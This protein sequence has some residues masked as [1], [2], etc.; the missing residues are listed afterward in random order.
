MFDRKKQQGLC[1]TEVTGTLQGRNNR[2]FVGHKQTTDTLNDKRSNRDSTGQK[3][4]IDTLQ[5]R[6]K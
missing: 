5:D 3:Q 6:R 4:V 2:A 1:R